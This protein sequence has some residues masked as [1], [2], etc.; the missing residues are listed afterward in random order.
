MLLCALGASSSTCQGDSGGPLT[1]GSPPVEVGIVDFGEQGCPADSAA[2]FTNV[3]AP[4]VRAFIEGS[5]SPPVAARPTSP[6]V[7]RAVGPARWTS[8]R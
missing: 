6:P 1:E 4:E 3:A 7:I 5:E 2:G 8:A